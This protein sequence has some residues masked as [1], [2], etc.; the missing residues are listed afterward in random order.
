MVSILQT[1]DTGHSD[2]I[3]DVQVDYY[4]LA[5]ATCSSDGTIKIFHL[6]TQEL[7]T[8]LKGHSGPINEL[9]WAHPKFGCLLA[10]CSFD[11]R[12]IIWKEERG[13]MKMNELLLN[14]A[15]TCIQFAPYQFGLSLACG[16]LDGKVN[17]VSYEN[18]SWIVNKFQA[19]LL[20]CNSL[21][22]E[23]S[24][25]D[26]R[27]LVTGGCDNSVKVW[28]ET[29]SGWEELAKIDAH[30]DSVV[31]VAWA[32]SSTVHMIASCSTD[33]TVVLSVST[34]KKNWTSTLLH[35]F[36]DPVSSVAW[37]QN[38]LAV[39]T[40]KKVFLWKENAQ[41]QWQ[42]VSDTDLQTAEPNVIPN[43]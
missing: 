17:I 22:W 3:L 30:K 8:E 36:Q 14:A 21:S 9:S 7:I 20:G 4:G 27:C 23:P 15:A 11:K 2:D 34:N 32:P 41:G 43:Q 31:G 40:S 29:V 13:W 24:S 5:M 19:H 16:S 37:G 1:L 25:N 6:K 28:Q 12:I 39:T 18:G 10:S 42:C 35:T 26:S 33:K 38:V